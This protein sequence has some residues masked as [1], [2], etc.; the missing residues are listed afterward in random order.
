MHQ[1]LRTQ[2]AAFL[3]ARGE[4]SF[5]ELKQAIGATDGNL[6]SHMAKFIDVG[7]VKARKEP[8][9]TGR[10]Q[11]VFSL[12]PVGRKA[13]TA[14]IA[15]LHALMVLSDAPTPAAPAAPRRAK[16]A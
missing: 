6:D 5:S 10:A 7:Y 13:L 3:A 14:Y 4:A 16:P 8:A 1:P 9:A 11:T 15:Q 12:T 2:I